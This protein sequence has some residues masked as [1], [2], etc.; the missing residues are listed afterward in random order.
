MYKKIV[1]KTLTDGGFTYSMMD[2]RYSVGT[3]KKS[4]IIDEKDFNESTLQNAVNELRTVDFGT[5]LHENQIH[6]D[7]VTVFHQLGK[8]LKVAKERGEIAIYDLK[9]NKEIFID[10]ED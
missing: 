2:G 4:V 1:E 6:V 8:A 7:S 10:Y 9:E 5:W 3:G